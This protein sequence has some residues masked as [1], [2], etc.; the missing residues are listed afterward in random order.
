[1][2]LKKKQ[3]DRRHQGYRRIFISDDAKW[4][5]CFLL[6]IFI[7]V[8][9]MNREAIFMKALAYVPKPLVYVSEC[10]TELMNTHRRADCGYLFVDMDVTG[11]INDVVR[12]PFLIL[13]STE[14][15]QLAK[16]VIY[17]DGGPGVLTSASEEGVGAWVDVLN[18]ERMAWLKGRDLIVFS[19]RGL[20][21]TYPALDCWL[22]KPYSLNSFYEYDNYRPNL[23]GI[24]D[25]ML[26]AIGECRDV[27][28]DNEL[29]IKYYDTEA[30]VHDLHAL[31]GPLDIDSAYLWGA[32]YGSWVSLSFIREHADQVAGAIL[33]GVY[34]PGI[35]D[36][37]NQ[38]DYFVETLKRI[39]DQC[40]LSHSCLESGESL[41]T[42][43]L[44]SLRSQK[45]SP[46][47]VKF[48]SVID[49]REKIATIDNLAY[50][51]VFWNS[52]YSP[53]GLR[54]A[55]KLMANDET[56]LAGQ[57]VGMA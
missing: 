39:A 27:L 37:I 48:T 31:I 12:I 5:K 50:L 40:R 23:D 11:Q 10:D 52:L 41:M 3:P 38:N 13:R 18:E 44:E 55:Q 24:I 33:E 21:D 15:T 19:Q 2:L 57:I 14:D 34:P 32:S 7:A 47:K 53:E 46:K 4:S 36:T 16:P 17:V 42:G 51:D 9:W 6:A 25:S 29:E 22:Y 8:A 28:R 54:V 43:F 30:I 20:P 35:V 1:M 56:A 45:L 49:G 26:L